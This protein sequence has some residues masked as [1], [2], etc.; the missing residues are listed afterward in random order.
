MKY[1][2]LRYLLAVIVLRPSD[3]RITLSLIHQFL[4]IQQKVKFT[5]LWFPAVRIFLRSVILLFSAFDNLPEFRFLC[6]IL[7]FSFFF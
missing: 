5:F 2:S 3:I 1:Q 6:R 7:N 4:D